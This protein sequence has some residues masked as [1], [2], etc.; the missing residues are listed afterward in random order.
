[1]TFIASRSARSF[2]SFSISSIMGLRYG[3]SYSVSIGS[4]ST[5]LLDSPPRAWSV[6]SGEVVDEQVSTILFQSLP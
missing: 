6:H 5:I 4:I 1:M 2:I 3:A